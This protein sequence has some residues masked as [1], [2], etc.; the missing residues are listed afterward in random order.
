MQRA[1]H[2][3][4]AVPILCAMFAGDARASSHREA[5]LLTEDPTADAT[6]LYMFTS[7][8]VA[9]TVTIIA[10][11]NP[12]EEPAGG[13]NFH[14]FS[15]R[16]LYELK[17]DN[18]GDAVEDIVYQFRFRTVVG[19]AGTFL[20]NTGPI[21]NIDD[22]DYNVKQFYDVTR[23]DIG[24][25]GAVTTTAV[26][27][28]GKVPPARVGPSSVGNAAAYAAIAAQAI[29]STTPN[30]GGVAR[31]HRTFCGPRDDPFF[32]DIGSVF[33]L[34]NS[35]RVSGFGADPNAQV[36]LDQ[37]AGFN[38]HSIAIQVPIQALTSN[39][40]LPANAD[41]TTAVIGAWTTS[42]RQKHSV[43]RRTAGPDQHGDF[44]QVSRLGLP[45]INEVVIPLS[46]KDAFNRSEPADDVASIGGF[47]LDPEL[48]RIVFLLYG[49]T[50]PPVPRDDLVS[51][52]SFLPD[53][54]GTVFA[55]TGAGLTKQS[56]QPADILRLN[57]ATTPTAINSGN[58]LGVIGGDIGGFP[59]GRRL[60]D[61]VT[62]ILERVVAGGILVP[63]F[64]VNPN[65]ILN[66]GV[67]G[68]DVAFLSAFPFVATPHDGFSHTHE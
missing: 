52:I 45:L 27:T 3:V 59:N 48:A 19:N 18:D 23:L 40:L 30:I 43:L 31:T 49:V 24:A 41:A 22:P 36:A 51:L 56:L 35:D 64:N 16:V 58:R 17:I 26:L 47:V 46:T 44:V 67:I 54:A 37:V 20:Y 65:N 60:Q 32:I 38:V 33:D 11:Y 9:N 12:F 63:G 50:V 34:I 2:L 4:A 53:P 25:L 21:T 28:N 1:S 55:G 8:D 66:D 39:G 29:T 10:N 14:G 68:N 62:D 13:P 7:P 42:S 15:E 57:L 6:D 5:P 61:D